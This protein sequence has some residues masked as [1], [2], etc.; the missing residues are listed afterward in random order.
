MFCILF[1]LNHAH[2]PPAL[3]HAFL[4]GLFQ[5]SKRL[6]VGDTSLQYNTSGQGGSVSHNPPIHSTL[7]SYHAN[8]ACCL[9]THNPVP[10]VRLSLVRYNAFIMHAMH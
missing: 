4:F 8:G 10:A 5:I 3:F 2:F 1:F 7:T 9:T 6:W